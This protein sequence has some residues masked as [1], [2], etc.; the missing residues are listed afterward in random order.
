MALKSKGVQRGLALILV[1]L[2]GGLLTAPSSN[3]ASPFTFADVYNNSSIMTVQ[4]ELSD[5][6]VASL[7]LEP[8][9]YTP[10]TVRFL[11]G[12]KDSG[13]I[14]IGTRLK[15]STSLEKLSGKPSMKIKFDYKTLS[16][17]RFLG[18]KNMT[19]NSMQQDGS[20]LH[21][22][23]AYRLFNA[24]GVPA[25]KT[26]WA[27]LYINGEDKGLY[28]NVE[29]VDDIFISKRL[30]DVT[31]HLYE[32]TAFQDIKA[33]SAGGDKN[34]GAFTVDEGWKKVPNKQDLQT[35]INALS[36][37]KD[38]TW[39]K[40]L[41]TYTDR[42]RLITQMAV[43]N[44]LGAWDAYSGPVINNY[45][46][47]SNG[48]GKFTMIPWGMDQT[49]GENRATSDSKDMFVFSM[50]SSKVSYP[51]SRTKLSRGVIYM[52]CIA[53]SPCKTEYLK[54]LKA[55][56]A[57]AT[58]I[59]LV[60]SMKAAAS[61]TSSLRNANPNATANAYKFVADQQA[62]VTSNS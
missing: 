50:L 60:A 58:S 16:K 47:R 11:L 54:A 13:I 26:G 44:F 36:T 62:R 2:T 56:S 23:G 49:F 48:A 27:R 43:E 20:K 21:E 17:Q 57:K 42:P 3:A 41:G 28:I 61:L 19:L 51:W 32:G 34:S 59:K 10:A 40:N 6:A 22:F 38:A 25:S 33:G 53:Y 12:D 39:W 14:N 29:N 7:N 24:M 18:L 5:T 9:K 37:N 4:L 45:F 30:K 15:G 8:K 46:I 52:R 1:A 35:L 31:N 55:V